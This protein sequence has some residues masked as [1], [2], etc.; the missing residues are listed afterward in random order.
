M[1]SSWKRARRWVL[2]TEHGSKA[3]THHLWVFNTT[4]LNREIWWTLVVSRREGSVLTANGLGGSPR[5]RITAITPVARTCEHEA[6]CAK[7]ENNDRRRDVGDSPRHGALFSRG[8]TAVIG[9]TNEGTGNQSDT[10]P[11]P[12]GCIGL[13]PKP[14]RPRVPERSKRARSQRERAVCGAGFV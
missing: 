2:S 8:A 3:A 4:I 10:L 1:F 12:S 11:G 13:A 6:R 7:H 9:F 14:S 5:H